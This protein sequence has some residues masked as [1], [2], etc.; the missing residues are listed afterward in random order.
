MSLF[1]VLLCLSGCTIGAFCLAEAI[2]HHLT[3][4]FLVLGSGQLGDHR[5][6][7]DWPEQ[8]PEARQARRIYAEEAE[9]AAERLAQGES[10]SKHW[11]KDETLLHMLRGSLLHVV[12]NVSFSYSV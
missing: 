9:M 1:V 4:L 3:F 12:L 7:E 10:V 2:K 11:H 5:G 8:R 6:A